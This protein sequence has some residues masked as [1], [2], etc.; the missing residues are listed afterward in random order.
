MPPG[1]MV[2]LGGA[3]RALREEFAI[4]AISAFNESPGTS[5][6]AALPSRVQRK[7]AGISPCRPCY[8]LYYVAENL[9]LG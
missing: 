9:V 7:T 8:V 2:T 4:S 1:E 3:M 6:N 5:V